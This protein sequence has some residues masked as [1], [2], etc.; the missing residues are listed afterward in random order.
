M[1][2]FAHGGRTVAPHDLLDAWNLDPIL[3]V[4]IAATALIYRRGLSRSSRPR[5]LR[6]WCFAGALIAITLAL[7]SPLE[8]MSGALASAHMV[9]HVLLLLVAAPMLVVGAPLRTIVRGMPLIARRWFARCRHALPPVARW[10]LPGDP[11]VLWLLHAGTIWFWHAAVPYGAALE[12][13]A[14]H[15]AEHASFMVTGVLFWRLVIHAQK[16]ANNG[17][18]V[19]L[20]FAMGV[21]S[22]FLSALLTFAPQ[23]W[24]EPY[25]ETTRVWGLDPLD[26]QQLA[27]VVMWVPAGAI[28]VG[29]ALALLL[30]W[31]RSVDRQALMD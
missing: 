5:A 4:A 12:S 3:L 30:A 14:I 25:T 16:T 2:V 20:V 11:V 7:V 9:Q 6:A 29:A 26:D 18:P 31:L 10:R 28:Y 24:Y 17:L 22:V 21:Q 15:V 27:G 23:P 8:A 1:D 13:E 19:L